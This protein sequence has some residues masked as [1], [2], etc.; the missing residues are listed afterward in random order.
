MSYL[1]SFP[2]IAMQKQASDNIYLNH[3]P[4]QTLPKP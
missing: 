2:I 1:V 3:N 4:G